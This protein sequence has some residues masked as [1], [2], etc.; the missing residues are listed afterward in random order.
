VTRRVN[1]RGWIVLE[2][3]PSLLGDQCVDL[4]ETPDGELGFEL[5]RAEP[6]DVGRWTAIGG[7]SD[8]RFSERRE[9]EAAVVAEVRWVSQCAE[10]RLALSRW[11]ASSS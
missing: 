7:F 9:V 4:F 1:H 11:A 5:L 8:S 2:S 10:A 6:E 3:I